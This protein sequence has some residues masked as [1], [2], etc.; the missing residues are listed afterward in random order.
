MVNIKFQTLKTLYQSN[1]LL[2]FVVQLL[3][4]LLV[5]MFVRLYQ[6]QGQLEGV[7]PVIVAEQ[8]N[9]KVFNLAELQGK[10]VLVHFWATWC[11]VCKL[12]NSNVAALT[13]EYTIITIAS[14][15]GAADDVRQYLQEHDL[16]MPVI[17][18]EDGEWARLYGVKGVPA[19][20][21]I[22]KSGMI[23]FVETGYT[24]EPGFRLRLWWLENN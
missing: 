13:E 12:E 14:W 21:F 2:R 16:H 9:G 18:D 3:L 4:I 11:P 5:V 8:L 24:T 7:A 22:N 6:S 19:S 1:R 20:F 15:S 10:E 17:V 23:S